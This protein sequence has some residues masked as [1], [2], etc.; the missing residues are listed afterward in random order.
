MV[1]L[2]VAVV[3]RS[4]PLELLHVVFQNCTVALAL[5]DEEQIRLGQAEDQSKR[6]AVLAADAD[7]QQRLTSTLVGEAK[8]RSSSCKDQ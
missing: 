3:I 8:L 2:I 5:R 6:G 1:L 7:L 4:S